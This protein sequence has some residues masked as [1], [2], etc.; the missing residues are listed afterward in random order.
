MSK[1]TIL[2]FGFG[3]GIS[4]GVAEL[5][6]SHGFRVGLVGRNEEKLVAGVRALEAKGIEAASFTADAGDAASVRKAI[7]AA[8][9]RFGGV[10]V[11]HWNA[12]GVGAAGDLLTV[13]P[14]EVASVFRVGTVG[15]LAAIQEALPDLRKAAATTKESAV[16]ITNGGLGDI[17]PRIDGMAVKLNAVGPALANAAKHKLA[18]LLS[19]RLEAEGI[20]VGEVVVSGLVKG[21][22]SDK[23]NATLDPTTV[24]QKFWDLYEAR[25]DL[26]ARVPS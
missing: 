22:P 10:Q 9:S 26:R 5:F 20:Y 13:D 17:D 21:T 11:I 15:L 14:E 16:L 23:G 2:V 19:T 12:P 8:R 18:G 25:K 3:P 1:A 7:A 4:A 24:A 6:G